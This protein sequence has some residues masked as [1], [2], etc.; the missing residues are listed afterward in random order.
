MLEFRMEAW[1]MPMAPFQLDCLISL[2]CYSNFSI[3]PG[4]G[5]GLRTQRHGWQDA[6]P[7]AFTPSLSAT[8]Y[9]MVCVLRCDSGTLILLISPPRQCAMALHGMAHCL[10]TFFASYA[11]TCPSRQIQAYTQNSQV[12]TSPLNSG[13]SSRSPG[14]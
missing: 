14:F 11:E 9:D 10:I 8:P 1:L 7:L 4:A 5:E 12:T 13:V 2:L 6:E 3:R